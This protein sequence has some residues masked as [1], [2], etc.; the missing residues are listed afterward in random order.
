MAEEYVKKELDKIFKDKKFPAPLNL[1]MICAWIMGNKKAINL[2][3]F[4]QRFLGFF[5]FFDLNFSYFLI[6]F[7]Q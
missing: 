2:N 4:F 5:P 7:L 3:Y 6:I 1:A